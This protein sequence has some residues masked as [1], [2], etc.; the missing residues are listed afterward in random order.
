MDAQLESG[1]RPPRPS[2]PRANYRGLASSP[3]T[4]SRPSITRSFATEDSV[5]QLSPASTYI[6]A[7]SSESE[8]GAK[9]SV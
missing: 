1:Q 9:K 5:S 8:G 6:A 3:L 7:S 4:A 2:K